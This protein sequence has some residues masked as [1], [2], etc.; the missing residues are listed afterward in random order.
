[1]QE[2]Q[3][4]HNSKQSKPKR[5]QSVHFGPGLVMAVRV[6]NSEV[7]SRYNKKR[8]RQT[9]MDFQSQHRK[10][11]S[12]KKVDDDCF[13]CD[14]SPSLPESPQV[15]A[16]EDLQ[17]LTLVKWKSTLVVDAGKAPCFS[18]PDYPNEIYIYPRCWKAHRL[19]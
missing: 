1:M 2:K 8:R 11:P 7:Q 17:S 13:R 12:V 3:H 16:P 15:S 6:L 14:A 19:Q 4:R 18:V 10:C 9:K 5:K